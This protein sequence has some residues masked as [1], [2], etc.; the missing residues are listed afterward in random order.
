MPEAKLHVAENAGRKNEEIR[1]IIMLV[2]KIAGLIIS[3]VLLWSSFPP[4]A[5]SD[6]AWLALVPLLLIIRNCSPKEAFRWGFLAGLGFWV[7]TLSWFPAIIKNGG[8]WYLVIL[9]QLALAAV[10]ALYMGLFACASASLWKT[11]G[12][13]S[14]LKR[15]GMICLADP[16]LWVGTEYMRA[17]LFSGFAWNFLGVSQV[18]NTALIQIA[19]VVGVYGVSAVLVMVNGGIASIVERAAF[20]VVTKA[21]RR[22]TVTYR[23]SLA[24]RFLRSCESFVPILFALLCWSWGMNRIKQWQSV[25]RYQPALRIALVQPNTPCRFVFNDETMRRQLKELIEQTRFAAAA[26]PHLVVWPETSL[27]GSVP[28]ETGTMNFARRGAEIAGNAL[29]AGT[30]ETRRVEKSAAAPDCMMYY[31]AAW[32]FAA[33]GSVLGSYRKQ[34]LVPFGEYIP[35]DKFFPVLQKLAPTGVSCSAGDGPSLM[36][37]PCGENLSVKVGALICFEDTVPGLSRL[38]VRA[39]ADLLALMTNDAWFNGSVEPV[40]HLNQSVFRAVECAVPLVRSANSGVSCVVDAVGRV[41][42]LTSQGRNTD[43]SGFLVAPVHLS[44]GTEISA[45]Y[46]TFGDWILAVPAALLVVFVVMRLFFRRKK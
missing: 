5:Q 26:E 7:F 39:G 29:L 41:R 8:P 45:P 15:V 2:F 30:L 17:S 14:S 32:M 6:S 13:G 4:C 1:N 20:P 35:L 19:S 11:A 38:S 42:E 40:Q 36:N 43:F 46:V 9:G 22:E 10:C 16:L 28:D 18:D 37:L 21:L 25:E 3:S 12:S 44:S 34:H 33:D 31:N 23:N 24:A 27:L